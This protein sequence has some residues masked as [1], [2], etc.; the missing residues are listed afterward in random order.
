MGANA[1]RLVAEPARG[2][3]LAALLLASSLAAP[4]LA[5]AVP[6]TYTLFVGGGNATG[7]VGSLDASGQCTAPAC[8]AFSNAYVTLTFDG[9]TADVFTFTVPGPNGDVTGAEISQ[10]TATFA[11]VDFSHVIA[12]GTFLPGAGIFVSVDQTNDGV[13]FGSHALPLGDPGF[14]G[15]PVYP[16]ALLTSKDAVAGYDLGKSDTVN[17]FFRP[18]FAISCLGFGVGPCEADPT[19]LALPTTAGDLVLYNVNIASASFT[20]HPHP[21]V[22][23]FAAFDASVEIR[24]GSFQVQG[25]FTLDPASDGI[26]PTGEDATLAVG[27][28]QVDIPAGSFRATRGGGYKF[29]GAV[30]GVQLEVKI[31]PRGGS[32]FRL[33]AQGKRADLSGVDEPVAVTLTIGNDT[34]STSARSDD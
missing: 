15:E 7:S 24:G 19:R 26:D 34:G 22:T 16:Y 31:S 29:E 27:P 3:I 25:R 1:I 23:P 8:T 28:Y 13:G 6:I 20:A 5:R 30:D 32:N 14:P 4:S 2:R 9:D 10:G 18:G 17:D 33:E 12:Q 11:I 21:A